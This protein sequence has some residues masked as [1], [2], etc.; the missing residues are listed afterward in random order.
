[1]TSFSLDELLD[2]ARQSDQQALRDLVEAS[3]RELLTWTQRQ[4][5]ADSL[6]DADTARLVQAAL[7]HAVRDFVRSSPRRNRPLME[8]LRRTTR[9]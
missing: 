1:M 3:R 6:D 4:P 9:E 5:Q 8:P 2:R 7:I